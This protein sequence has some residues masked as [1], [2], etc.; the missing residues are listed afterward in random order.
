MLKP[1]LELLD[2]PKRILM[3]ASAALVFTPNTADRLG[4]Q[5]TL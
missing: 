1:S 2:I 5:K 3:V 4:A